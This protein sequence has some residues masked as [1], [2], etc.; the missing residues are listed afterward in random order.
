VH[1]HDAAELLDALRGLW[2]KF[3]PYALSFLVLGVRWLSSVQVRYRAE[4][5]SSDYTR[6][7]MM[8]MLLVTCVPFSTLVV[9]RFAS[10]APAIWLYAANTGLI[11]AIALRMLHLLPD[12]EDRGHARERRISQFLLIL[13]SVVAV[14][15]SFADAAPALWAYLLNLFAPAISRW[16][17]ARATAST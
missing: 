17:E 3:F 12:V 10:L 16:A 6:W 2:P 11:G 4:T 14:A 8:Y 15:I 1:P 13:S 7:W 9:G 5:L